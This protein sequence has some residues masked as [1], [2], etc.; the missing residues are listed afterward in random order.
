MTTFTMYI[1]FE[2]FCK[3]EYLLK[4]NISKIYVR[5]I[6]KRGTFGKKY[7]FI[8]NKLNWCF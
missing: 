5:V 6:L 4:L 2:S 1:D 7:F 8:K 3:L